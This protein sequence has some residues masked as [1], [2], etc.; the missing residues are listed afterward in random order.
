MQASGRY[1]AAV[2]EH[3]EAR[4]WASTEEVMA[5]CGVSK[6]TVFR[7]A[8]MGLLP[9]PEVVYA[10]GRYAR[11]QLHAPAQATWVDGRLKAGWTTDEIRAALERGEFSPPAS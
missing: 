1:T 11:W 9:T 7:W 8:K 10:R 2:P 6:P 3:D 4:R 5:A